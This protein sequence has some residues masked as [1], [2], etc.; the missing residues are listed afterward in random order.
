[1]VALSFETTMKALKLDEL[2]F[3]IAQL[4]EVRRELVARLWRRIHSGDYQ[5]DARR[6]A[7]VLYEEVGSYLQV[8]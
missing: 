2:M 7:Q 8:R 5:V 3:Q 4:P 1:M 6:L